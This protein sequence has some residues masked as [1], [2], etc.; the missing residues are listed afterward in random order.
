MSGIIQPISKNLIAE[1]SEFVYHRH[2]IYC[3]QTYDQTLPYSFHLK[4]VDK[5]VMHYGV[6]KI[7]SDEGYSLMVSRMI[8]IG[9]D[10]IEDA[11]M[12]YNDIKNVISGFDG[13]TQE[14]QRAYV[15]ERVADGIY[16]CT[17]VRGKNRAERHGI[18]FT[19]TLLE[20]SPATFVKLCDILANIR[21]SKL[22][23]S[24][25]LKAYK[26]EF[27]IFEKQI[28]SK[29]QQINSYGIYRPLIA[30]VVGDIQKE[31]E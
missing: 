28:W 20:N 7:D 3:N 25:M 23:Q 15:H 30:Y 22:T 1:W 5:N 12:T 19:N 2:D 9:H 14:Y 17:N 27:P 26:K 29:D 11:R 24:G 13:F 6:N 21:F 18:E 16:C 10:L 31:L 4:C 8:A